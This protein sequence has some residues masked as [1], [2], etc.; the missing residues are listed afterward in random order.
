[1]TRISL[2]E[3]YDNRDVIAQIARL[4]DIVEDLP[5]PDLTN[6]VLKTGNQIIDGVK[7]F[8]DQV[9]LAGGMDLTGLGPTTING[10]LEVNGDIIQSGA[11]YETHAEQVF[12]HNDYIVMRDGAVNSLPAGSYSGL[13]IKKYDGTNDCRMVVDNSG[14]MRVGEVNDEQPLMT[15][16][17]VADMTSGNFVIWDGVNKKAITSSLAPS[18]VITGSGNIG[19]DDQ[20]VKIVSGS[21]VGISTSSG[22]GSVN[23][24]NATTHD[25]HPMT[26]QSRG[27]ITAAAFDVTIAT[28]ATTSSTYTDFIIGTGFPP[29]KRPTGF[30]GPLAAGAGFISIDGET[31]TGWCYV[32]ESGN[33]RVFARNSA[34]AGKVVLGA[35]TY[36]S[37]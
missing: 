5:N 14:T 24:T 35:V 36:I 37:E 1:M 27:G 23:A 30:Y 13:Q 11:A 2:K 21:P 22:S 25:S 12:S 19:D 15:R 6:V 18:G 32:D 8:N 20:P 4:N 34:L 7:Q 3:A 33:L 9:I 17:E 26:W 16:D 10:D 29:S 28:N 31:M